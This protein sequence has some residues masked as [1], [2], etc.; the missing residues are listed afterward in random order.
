MSAQSKSKGRKVDIPATD[1]QLIAWHAWENDLV[2]DVVFG[3]AAGGGKS[4]FACQALTSTAIKYPKSRQFLGRKELKT[5]M[6]TSYIT[7]T[8]KVF[9]QY[10]YEPDRDW[11]LDGKYNVIHFKNGSTINL[12]DLAFAPTDPLF[13]RFGSHEYTRGWIEEASEVNFKAYDV[14]KSRV[15]RYLNSELKIKSKLGLSLNPSQD[16][17]YRLFYDPWKKAG[18]PVDPDKPLISIKSFVDGKEVVRTFVFI[19][20]LYKDNPFTS[21]EY[22]RSLATISDP[23]LKARLMAGDWEYASA[24]DTL[25]SAQTIAD[26]F[27]STA[28]ESVEMFLTVDVAR[29]GGDEIV[30]TH[31]RGWD[32][33]KIDRYTMLRTN[34]TADKIRT[35]AD[36]Y[37]IPRENTLIDEDGLGGG[38]LDLVPGALGFTGDASPFGKIGE[39]EVKENYQNL[40]TQCVYY[41][42]EQAR[43]RRI[44]VS[45]ENLD[46]REKIAQDLAQFKRRD[47]EI[48]EGKLKIAKKED[49]KAA[50]GRSPDCGDTLMMRSYFDLRKREGT[51]QQ[52]RNVKVK[53]FDI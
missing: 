32:A 51:I 46:T 34:Q 42:A 7:L 40:K 12:L 44:R 47:A 11:R 20:A 5:L 38:V 28:Q 30:L 48:G 2:D 3:G 50:L 53:T 4:M 52:N 16:W 17:P 33:F 18:R 31:W 49:M 26:I 15:G 29:F 27:T 6:Q 22:S 35:A 8:Q 43:E 25:F 23:V 45:E 14:L 39:T 13:D 1:K 24:A 19:P 41:L 9:P 36:S 21:N 10:G 37:G